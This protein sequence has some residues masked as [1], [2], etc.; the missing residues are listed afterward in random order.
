M[1]LLNDD[2]WCS[3]LFCIL[4]FIPWKNFQHLVWASS[5]WNVMLYSSE[6]LMWNSFHFWYNRCYLCPR[7]FVEDKCNYQHFYRDNL[8]CNYS[9]SWYLTTFCTQITESKFN[10]SSR[11]ELLADCFQTCSIQVYGLFSLARLVVFICFSNIYPWYHD[12]IDDLQMQSTFV[13]CPW[14][15]K[16]YVSCRLKRICAR[17]LDFS[18]IVVRM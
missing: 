16:E 8:G 11:F 17:L 9:D 6:V 2:N 13:I 4:W 15:E 5:S 18:W 12:R 3:S 1:H 10:W 7:A 14:T